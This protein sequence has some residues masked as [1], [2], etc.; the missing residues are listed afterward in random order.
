MYYCGTRSHHSSSSVILVDGKD[1]P[2][3]LCGR[4]L[5]EGHLDF[6]KIER[7]ERRKIHD[8]IIMDNVRLISSRYSL[9]IRLKPCLQELRRHLVDRIPVG[10][11]LVVSF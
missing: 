2:T 3:L 7:K 6:S 11:K 9:L 10:A 4:S 5:A 8:A 1:V